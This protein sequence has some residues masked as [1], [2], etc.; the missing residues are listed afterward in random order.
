ME[1]PMIQLI[2]SKETHGKKAFN[3]VWE[4]GDGALQSWAIFTNFPKK[5]HTFLGILI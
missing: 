1:F 5:N 3:S 4:S 2:C